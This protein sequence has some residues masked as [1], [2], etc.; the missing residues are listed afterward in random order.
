MAGKYAAPQGSAN[1][2]Y[3]A[4]VLVIGGGPAGTWAAVCAAQ[5]GASV[6]LA[7]KGYCGSSGATAAAG[8]A[9]W[10]VDP[11]PQKRAAAMSSRY[12]MG[13]R[14]AD[15]G[16][17]GR[18]LD[19][20]WDGI[21]TLADWGYPFP[22]DGDGVSRRNSLQGPE[23]MRLMRK[24]V[25]QAGGRILDH[26]PVLELLRDE[27]GAVAGAAG[28]DRQRGGAW[29][30][31][32]GAV[33]IATGGCAFLSRA[34]GCNVLTGDGLLMAAELGAELSGMEFSNAYGIAPEFGSVTKTLFYSWATFTDVDGVPIPGAASKGGRSVIAR[35]LL[36][37]KVYARLDQ[38]D[39]ATRQAM[40]A[41]QP[42]FFLPFDRSG[43]DPFTQRFPVTL[44]LE[45]TVRGTGGLRLAGPDCSTTVPGLYAAGDAATRE[46]I[47]GGFTGGGSHNA[48]W[49][50]SSG[51]WAGAGAAGHALAARGRGRTV[52]AAGAAGLR[53]NGARAADAAA[54][55]RAVQDEVMPFER[56]YFRTADVLEPSVARLDT[57]W[58][59]LR[60]AA[61]A[62]AAD[63]LATREAAAMLAT[64]RWMYRSA[65][66]R[67]ETRGMH[68][69][70]DFLEQDAAQ[71]HHLSAGGLDEVWVQPRALDGGGAQSVPQPAP[72]SAT[73]TRLAA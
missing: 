1:S 66:A 34:L 3:E 14:L 55:V 36:R 11:D 42:N 69:R 47:C 21:N 23:Y 71:Y 12:D 30:V 73:Q 2:G 43:I 59:G 16:W 39:E 62:A 61:P 67:R 9:V 15:H 22:V 44:R 54:L 31:R 33:V 50:I 13:G 45:G 68:K 27:H 46:P 65:L 4:D 25:K 17:M 72:Q 26:H 41:A 38:A 53:G 52:I 64:S 56:N 24:Q 18:V 20:T 28:V 40:R 60:S 8:T 37:Q 35:E 48:A 57:R 63:L 58:H 51:S 49:A 5:A 70:Y 6:I 32:A 29:T 19:R 7:D 10:Y